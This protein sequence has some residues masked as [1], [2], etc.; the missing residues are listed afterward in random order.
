M[1]F[2]MRALLR[3][4]TRVRH[5]GYARATLAAVTGGTVVGV[6]ASERTATCDTDVPIVCLAA[7]VGAGAA[8]LLDPY[9]GMSRR[10]GFK[11]G[12]MEARLMEASK[13]GT[14]TDWSNLR[15]PLISFSCTQISLDQIDKTHTLSV[16]TQLC[17][18]DHRGLPS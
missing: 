13:R 11:A 2:R 6:V 4:T 7:L 8:L 1:A 5:P 18:P 16:L 3:A 14:V 17:V 12:Y 10:E 9:A 15:S